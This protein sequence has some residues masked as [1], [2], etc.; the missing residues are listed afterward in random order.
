MMGSHKWIYP[1]S[2]FC[3]NRSPRDSKMGIRGQNAH[4]L[5]SGSNFK[6][7]ILK[8]SSHANHPRVVKEM[9]NWIIG[10]EGHFPSNN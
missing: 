4:F 6:S 10:R 1:A 2:D 3:K 9:V 5:K 8:I 7:I